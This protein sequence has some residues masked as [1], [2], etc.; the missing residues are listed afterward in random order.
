MEKFEIKE[1]IDNTL[2]YYSIER[3]IVTTPENIDFIFYH[4]FY[5]GVDKN[6][7]IKE[8]YSATYIRIFQKNG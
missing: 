8:F 7:C 5:V 6:G 3:G 1:D 4:K 2:D